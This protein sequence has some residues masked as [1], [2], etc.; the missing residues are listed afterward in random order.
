MLSASKQQNDRQRFAP[1][2][3]RPEQI[4]EMPWEQRN[5]AAGENWTLGLTLT[6]GALYHWATAACKEYKITTFRH[7]SQN[8]WS[9]RTLPQQKTSCKPLKTPL[10]VKIF[11]TNDNSW[12]YNPSKGISNRKILKAQPILK[13]CPKEIWLTARKHLPAKTA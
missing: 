7:E 5:G 2:Y 1:P 4:Q 10:L 6:K 9:A 13:T 3:R 8:N 12:R 11:L